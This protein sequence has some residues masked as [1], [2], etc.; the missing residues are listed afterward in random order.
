MRRIILT[1]AI[2]FA[3][4]AA[5]FTADSARGAQLFQTLDCGGCHSVNGRGARIAGDLTKV[6]DRDYTP[7]SFTATM[8]NHAT[9]MW[10]MMKDREIRTGDLHPQGAADLLAYFYSARFF[11]HPGDA[12]R[13]VRLFSEKHCM[14]CHGD[15]S[16]RPASA[17]PVSQWTA[18]SDPVALV[19][20]MW[21]H[22]TG[23]KQ[24]FAERK[25][26]WPALAPQDLA[27]I[28]VYVRSVNP[29]ASSAA[30]LEITSGGQ[31]KELFEN[32]KC[33]ACHATAIDLTARLRHRTLTEIAAAMWNHAS[34]MSAQPAPIN[35]SEMQ[36]LISYLWAREYFVD[37]GNA[38]AGRRVFAAKHCA[39][40]H[41]SGSEGAPKLPSAAISSSAP[42]MIAALWHHGPRMMEQMKSKHIPWPSFTAAQM[43]N[44]IAYLNSASHP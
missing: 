22:S 13:G 38:G 6:G 17:K 24:Q 25:W 19:G 4:R 10:G 1:L 37:A 2:A 15:K 26:A 9:V 32:K 41:E 43:S 33:S 8:W 14:D 36:A 31:G 29:L 44:L 35:P 39:Q 18:V 7:A 16:N 27:D 40:C 11:E 12:G 5:D 3:S 28:L 42:E 21:N 34:K 23:M 20:E 30:R